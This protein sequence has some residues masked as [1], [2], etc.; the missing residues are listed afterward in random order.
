MFT[1][2]KPLHPLSLTQAKPGLRN[3]MLHTG[4][5]TQYLEENF[6]KNNLELI[7]SQQ[8]WRLPLVDEATKLQLRFGIKV[9]LREIFFR[10]DQQ[11]LVYGRTLF[12]AN[13]LCSSDKLIQRLGNESLGNFLFSD[14]SI[15]RDKL[16]FA[17]LGRHDKLFNLI[18]DHV[19]NNND[20]LYARRS[21]FFIRQEPILVTEI[22]FPDAFK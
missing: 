12:P 15:Y 1:H 7:L 8:A 3:C 2:W 4:S 9:L 18:N 6:C 11:I 19:I 20:M 22:F 17:C 10:C 16:E 21:V 13:T 14:K 5:L